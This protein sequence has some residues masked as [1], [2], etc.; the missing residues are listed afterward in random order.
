[1]AT[2]FDEQNS[3]FL[4]YV[5]KSNQKRSA[6][7][8]TYK[9]QISLVTHCS[10]ERVGTLPFSMEY[11]ACFANNNEH[12][13]L[14]FGQ[15]DVHQCYRSK[16]PL[17]GFTTIAKSYHAHSEIRMASSDSQLTFQFEK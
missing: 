17:S 8:H 1:M 3:R 12:I 16:Q 9:H 2:G 6:F 15:D 4:N 11:G 10:L 13:V 7:S 5:S 14:C